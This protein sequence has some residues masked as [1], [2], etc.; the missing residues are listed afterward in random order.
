MSESAPPPGQLD[1]VQSCFQRCIEGV[2][3][4]MN[5]SDLKTSSLGHRRYRITQHCLW[6]KKKTRSQHLFSKQLW[7]TCNISLPVQDC[8]SCLSPFWWVFTPLSFLKSFLYLFYLSID[9]LSRSLRY[10][11]KELLKIPKRNLKSSGRFSFS[12][13]APSFWNSLS[14]PLRN[15]PT[16]FQIKFHLRPLLFPQHSS[17]V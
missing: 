16:L 12:F 15:V 11:N 14:T 7:E 8:D 2:L 1:T 13:M 9:E 6:W 17:R 10:S 5:I 3:L 4:W